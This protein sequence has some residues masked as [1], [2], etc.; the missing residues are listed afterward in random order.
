MA[1]PCACVA[2]STSRSRHPG[3]TC[4]SLA[5]G[6]DCDVAHA[7]HVER[8]TALGDRGSGHVVAPALDAQQ[9]PVVTRE[10][11]SRQRRRAAEVGWRTSAG[12]FATMP[13][14]T[15][16]ASSQPASPA[17]KQRAFDPRVELVELLRRQPHEIAVESG[18]IDRAPL[19]RPPV[20]PSLSLAWSCRSS[21]RCPGSTLRRSQRDDW[22]DSANSVAGSPSWPK[23]AGTLDDRCDDEQHRRGLRKLLPAERE[24]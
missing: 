24:P 15:S 6:V 4:A 13:F 10:P 7:R 3:P 18:D 19:R 5:I 20:V 11:D 17:R 16:T 8:Q 12:T 9:Q 23:T 2:R 1:S 14:Q 21:R 22:R